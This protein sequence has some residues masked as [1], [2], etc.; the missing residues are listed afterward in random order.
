MN[1]IRNK[2]RTFRLTMR[3]KFVLSLSAI[4]AMLL[5]CSVIALMEY[6]RMSHYVSDLISDNI[7]SIS[8]AEKVSDISRSYNLSVMNTISN[9]SNIVEDKALPTFDVEKFDMHCDSLKRSFTS[10]YMIP[11][12]DSVVN[13]YYAYMIASLELNGEYKIEYSNAGLWY[14]DRLKP[15]YDKLKSD[16]GNLNEGIYK[17]LNKNSAT[18]DRGFYRSVVPGAVAVGFAL[19]LILL[20]MFFVIVYYVNPIAKILQGLNGYRAY[21]KQYNYEFDGDDELV[22]LNEGVVELVNENRQLRRRI[23]NM[24]EKY[25]KESKELKE[26]RVLKMLEEDE[27]Q[28]NI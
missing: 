10:E 2:I 22:E 4:A 11:L 12:V 19:L 25:S 1:K 7:S 23:S 8:L 24:R 18:F 26:L 5:V 20:L 17:E 9:K 16:I 3:S 13:S 6:K 15:K 14:Q 28:G 21:N 27:H